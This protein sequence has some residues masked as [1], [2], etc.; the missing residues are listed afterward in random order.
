MFAGQK[1]M[2]Q[3]LLPSMYT[4]MKQTVSLGLVHDKYVRGRQRIAGPGN[5]VPFMHTARRAA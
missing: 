4:Q 5:I 3:L 2:T 1:K